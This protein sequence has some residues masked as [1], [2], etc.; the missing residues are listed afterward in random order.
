VVILLLDLK[1]ELMDNGAVSV[2]FGN[3]SLVVE[4]LEQDVDASAELV[5]P[6]QDVQVP[7]VYSWEVS[8]G[9]GFSVQGLSIYGGRRCKTSQDER[10]IQVW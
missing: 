5:A 7:V 8:V 9:A 1:V 4:T 6:F 10:L 2:D 3:K